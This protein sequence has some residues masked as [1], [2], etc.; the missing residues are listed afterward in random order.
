MFPIRDAMDNASSDYSNSGS[1]NKMTKY[2]SYYGE[3]VCP[4]QLKHHGQDY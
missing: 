3:L 4:I 2:T 1:I